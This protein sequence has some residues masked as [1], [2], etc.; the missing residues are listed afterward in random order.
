ML[1]DGGNGVESQAFADFF[2]SGGVA[3]LVCVGVN[4]P[5]D[6]VFG[7]A[8]HVNIVTEGLPK[9]IHNS[10]LQLDPFSCIIIVIQNLQT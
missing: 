10:C 7:G 5:D 1:V 8:K 2:E 6:L 4:K 3:L 9:V